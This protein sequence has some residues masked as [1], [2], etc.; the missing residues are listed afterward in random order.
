[1]IF[2]PERANID[3]RW[4]K[5]EHGYSPLAMANLANVRASGTGSIIESFGSQRPPYNERTI[6]WPIVV[7]SYPDFVRINNRH[8]LDQLFHIQDF[9]VDSQGFGRC[10]L[11][12]QRMQPIRCLRDPQ[13]ALLTET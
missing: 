5:A 13:T 4:D 11:A 7:P 12:F 6:T 9:T 1:M 8:F 2:T 3:E 10:V